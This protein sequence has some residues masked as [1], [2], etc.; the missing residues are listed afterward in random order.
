MA[1]PE[2]KAAVRQDRLQREAEQPLVTT[3]AVLCGD[4]ADLEFLLEGFLVGE[5]VIGGGEGFSRRGGQQIDRERRRGRAGAL[6]RVTCR[7]GAELETVERRRRPALDRQLT[8]PEPNR[9][10]I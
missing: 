3:T 6:T 5:V 4:V 1:V 8:I 7:V 9:R 2:P 10:E